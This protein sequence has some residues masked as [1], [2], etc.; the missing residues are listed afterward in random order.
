LQLHREHKYADDPLKLYDGI[1]EN[2]VRQLD[3]CKSVFR[4]FK[5]DDDRMRLD[6]L[7][8]LAFE[9]LLRDQLDYEEQELS[10]LVFTYDRLKEKATRFLA[11]E[12]L[13]A[14]PRYLADDA[15]ATPLLREIG[16]GTFAFAHLALQEYLAAQAFAV[17]CRRNEFEGVKTFC[18]A[19]FNTTL[20][21]MEVLPQALALLTNPESFC[22]LIERLPDSLTVSGYRLRLRSLLYGARLNRTSLVTLWKELSEFVAGRNGERRAYRELIIN[23]LPLLPEKQKHAIANEL[24]P[25]LSDPSKHIRES[26]A[27]A[28][29]KLNVGNNQNRTDDDWNERYSESDEEIESPTPIDYRLYRK[30]QGKPELN[31][32]FEALEDEN[33]ETSF[34]GAEVLSEIGGQRVVEGLIEAFR[35]GAIYTCQSA[36]YALGKIGGKR[37]LRGMIEAFETRVSDRRELAAAALGEIGDEC[38]LDVLIPH[39]S[40]DHWID[41]SIIAAIGK[42]GGSRAVEGLI[43]GLQHEH[44]SALAAHW[45]Q[46]LEPADLIRG[47]MAALSSDYPYVRKK[48][49]QVIGYYL[50]DPQLTTWLSWYVA[51]DPDTEIR[52]A[53]KEAIERF[54]VK[55]G[56]LGFS[57]V[58]DR[59]DPLGDNESREGVLVGEVT[60]AVFQAGHIYREVLKS[61][62][63]I[64]GE[65]E[66]K[67]ERGKASGQR[68]YLQLKSGDSYL[69]KRKRDNKEI[70]AILPRHAEYWQSHA[71]PVLLVIRDSGG[72]IRWMNV[73]EYLQR[74][75]RGIRQI[76][77]QGEPFSPASIREMYVRFAR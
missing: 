56:A 67:N 16:T 38:A 39:L 54:S 33:I 3:R 73:T 71:Y 4:N 58:E 2:L 50:N 17:F 20:V 43:K 64:D 26:A 61:D 75:G 14:N 18:Q 22:R 60:T 63:G 25:L 55:L 47:L 8:F 5:L 7:K 59:K 23:L 28:V 29:R 30:F 66:F 6:F 74:H 68:V 48:V 77:F 19:F 12:Y 15:L 70:F 69:R 10:R 51:N 36:A 52:N 76:E 13:P 49:I 46:R 31:N 21:E 65:I 40:K 27:Q 57:I 9:I 34:A 24:H 32:L 11:H 45:L 62:W 37:A 44:S 53:A 41:E 35:H 1:I 72:Q 42:I